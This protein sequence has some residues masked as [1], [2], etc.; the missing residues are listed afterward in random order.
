MYGLAILVNIIRK[1]IKCQSYFSYEN[2]TEFIPRLKGW[3]FSN[4][5]NHIK[6]FR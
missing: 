6:H 5:E 2:S 4:G 3:L 1:K